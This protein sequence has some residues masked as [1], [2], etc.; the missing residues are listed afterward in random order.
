VPTRATTETGSCTPEA[1]R[2]L[3]VAR[4]ELQLPARLAERVRGKKA[5][6]AALVALR[7]MTQRTHTANLRSPSQS[8]RNPTTWFQL[9]VIRDAPLR[10]LTSTAQWTISVDKSKPRAPLVPCQRCSA[11]ESK[12]DRWLSISGSRRR[13]SLFAR[14]R[15]T[16]LKASPP[17]DNAI[18]AEPTPT[19]AQATR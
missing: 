2:L 18:V 19:R 11:P 5:R 7:G 16:P 15:R 10:G 12:V 1:L 3:E 13:R 8:V 9:G 6:F 17:A 4:P 14:F